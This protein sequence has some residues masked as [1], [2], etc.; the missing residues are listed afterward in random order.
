MTHLDHRISSLECWCL[1]VVDKLPRHLSVIPSH[2]GN[3][4]SSVTQYCYPCLSLSLSGLLEPTAAQCTVQRRAS[5]CGAFD[6][7][8]PD[9]D[10]WVNALTL[11]HWTASCRS[12]LASSLDRSLARQLTSS[13]DRS[14]RIPAAV[15]ADSEP[16]HLGRMQTLSPTHEAAPCLSRSRGDYQADVNGES[17]DLLR[18]LGP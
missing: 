3:E 17:V 16:S 2:N 9:H 7:C 4:E 18:P 14:L 12:L 11:A 6:S 8:Q 10:L 5:A 1:H 13:F 15:A